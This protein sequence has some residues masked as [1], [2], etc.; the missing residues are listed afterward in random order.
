[1]NQETF[2]RGRV[3]DGGGEREAGGEGAGRGEIVGE[4]EREE[5]DSGRMEGGKGQGR[6]KQ[7]IKR[8]G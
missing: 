7:D 1:M 5:G 2:I 8:T 6:D 4:R 3:G